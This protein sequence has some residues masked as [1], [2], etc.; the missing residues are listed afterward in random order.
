MRRLQHIR[1]RELSLVLASLILLLGGLISIRQQWRAQRT[2]G[3]DLLTDGVVWRDSPSGVA[4]KSAS[5]APRGLQPG[6]VLLS[7]NGAPVNDAVEV[8]RALYAAG[9]GG[10]L[11]YQVREDSGAIR[12]VAATARRAKPFRFRYLYEDLTGLFYFALGAFIFVRRHSARKALHFCWFSLSSFVLYCYHY[13]G[14]LNAFDWTVY[15]SN[16]VA[17]LLTPALF[18]HFALVFPRRKGIVQRLPFLI[19]F[20]YA[21]GLLVLLAEL[22]LSSNRVALAAPALVVYTW[23]DHLSYILFAVYFLIA[24]LALYHSRRHAIGSIQR[25]QMSWL[26]GGVLVAVLPFLL[27]YVLP[28]LVDPHAALAANWVVLSLIALPAAFAYAIVRFRLMDAAVLF[29]RG[30]AYTLATVAVAGIY[31]AVLGTGAFFIHS[32]LPGFGPV[33]WVLAIMITALLFDPVKGWIQERLDRLFYRERYDYRRTLIEFGRQLNAQTDLQALLTELAERLASTLILERVAVFLAEQGTAPEATTSAGGEGNGFW[34]ARSFGFTGRFSEPLRLQFLQALSADPEKDLLFIE[35]PHHPA[36]ADAPY[37]STVAALDLNYYLPCRIQGRTVAVL[38]LGRTRSGDLLSSEDVELLQ[39]L[40]GY[41]AVA[42]ENTRLYASLQAQISEYERLKEFNENIVESIAVGV[43]AVDLQGRVESWNAQMEVLSAQPRGQVLGRPI[44]EVLGSQFGAEFTRLCQ[45]QGIRQN[46]KMRMTLGAGEARTINLAVA[47]LLTR[48]FEIVGHIVL[49]DDITMQTELEHQLAQAERLG[50]VGLLAAGVAHEVNTPLA[51][52][53]SYTQL[54]AKQLS[55]S[56]PRSSVL[57]KITRQTFRASE[58]IS[59][60][61]NFSRSANNEMAELDLNA[62][63]GETLSLLEHPLRSAGVSVSASFEDNLPRVMGNAG[64]L[65]QVFLNLALNARDA[66]PTGGDLSIRTWA[67]EDRIAVEVRD[68]GS[69]IAPEAR[70]RI[71]DP[72]FTTKH[73]ERARGA[74]HSG[75]GLGLSV[76]YA[77]LQEHGG[78]ISVASEPGEGACFLLELPALRRTV[79]A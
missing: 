12:N 79:H 33:S 65:Q 76:S 72:F 51:V 24:A 3:F 5:Q 21:P 20:L 8:T 18:L 70:S 68:S 22:A 34:L 50:T 57:D 30:M 54:L 44:Q 35:S 1:F 74:L 2:R 4:V 75:T 38:G 52:I 42:I 17:L 53:S 78:T 77:I 26:T 69:G 58:I 39:T 41:L 55:P 61:L 62:V 63:I 36:A 73:A 11:S 6:D 59:S 29:R 66:M 64:R 67:R 31:F 15:W 37:L 47:P 9:I 60:L 56:D 13:T 16:E 7:V 19:A 32:R 45:H 27:L 14:K 10:R 23:L 28:A 71:F 25:Q 46:S 49:V 48:R 40:A 43:A